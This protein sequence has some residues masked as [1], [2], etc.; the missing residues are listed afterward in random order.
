MR[1]GALWLLVL[2]GPLGCNQPGPRLNA[3]PHGQP[4][5]TTDLQGTFV[6]MSDNALLADM[7][8]SDMHFLPHRA[9]L[10]TL[11][12]ER[13]GRLAALIEEYGGTIRFST[14][15]TDEQ[16][17]A[18]RMDAVREFLREIGVEAGDAI[19]TRDVPGGRGMEATE[20][21]EIKK[22]EGTY[23]PDR[24]SGPEPSGRDNSGGKP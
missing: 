4:V 23:R 2:A 19:L 1:N 17:I 12:Q 10:T 18:R 13:L 7:S 3:P 8:I 14:N 16:L 21:V 6:Y 9:Q 15:L 11:G 22:Q 5:E 24:K 20:A